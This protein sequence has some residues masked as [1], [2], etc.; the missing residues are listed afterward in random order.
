MLENYVGVENFRKGL[1]HYLTK[2]RYSNAEGQDLWNS[3]G[4]IAHKPVKPMMK[5]WI[6]IVGYPIVTAQRENS[7]GRQP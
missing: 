5:T 7:H 4:S 1:K 3:I 6:D 2:Y